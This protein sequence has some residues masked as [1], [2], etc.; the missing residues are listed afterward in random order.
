MRLPL[1]ILLIA[2]LNTTI[3]PAAPLDSRI[4]QITSEGAARR[5]IWGVY[6][7]D[8]KA[9]TVLADLNGTRLLTPAS[10]RKLVTTALVVSRFKPDQRLSTELRADA[11]TGGNVSGDI[12][13]HAA[14][15]PSWTPELLGGRTGQSKISEIAQLAREAGLRRVQG[16]LVIDTGCYESMEPIPPGWAWDE[17]DASYAGRPAALSVNENLVGI[18][19][20]PGRGNEPLRVAFPYQAEPFEI[21]NQSRTLGGGSAP[22]LRIVRRLDG[23]AI[24]LVG[25]LPVDAQPAVRSIPAGNPVTLIANSLKAALE[26]QGVTIDGD[27]RFARNVRKGPVVLASVSGATMAEIIAVCNRESDNFLAESLYLAC[28]ADRFGSASYPG[29]Y[30][31]EQDF[32]KKIGVDPA[33]INPAD[34]CGLSRENAISPRA[35][36]QLLR[37]NQNTDWFTASLP[38]SGRTGTLRYRLSQNGMASRVRAKT[39]TL[40]AASSLSG[41]LT[42]NSGKTVIFSIMANNYTGGK[43]SIRARI[44]DIVELLAQR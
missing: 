43:E 5:A 24:T 41:Y 33:E 9:G 25:G 19:I 23:G 29:G 8:A 1:L 40:D 42:T 4:E 6:A 39:G 16:D 27:I 21:I 13:L 12:V 11:L 37:A 28:A 18:S 34:G 30:K 38:V 22:T 17:L 36:V 15:D 44:D 26:K 31:L 10:N 7:I 35:L 14:G 32:W 3:L 20:S 2:L